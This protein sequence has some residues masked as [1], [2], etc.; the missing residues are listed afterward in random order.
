MAVDEKR[1]FMLLKAVIYHY[2]GLDELERIDL[3]LKTILLL[4]TV[5]EF[6]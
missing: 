1:V 5:L 2:H 4:L 3:S 6:T